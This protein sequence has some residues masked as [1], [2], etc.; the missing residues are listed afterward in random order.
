M[1]P[2]VVKT[3]GRLKYRTSYGQNVLVHSIE[4]A[5]LSANLAAELGADVELAK[6]AGLLHDIGKVI[7]HEIESSHAIIG[8]E[9]LKKFGE[10]KSVINAVA[11]HHGE[12]E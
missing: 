2:E 4:V 5:K 6:R 11:A 3:L 10:Q 7:D 9:F 12:V 1:H 8:A